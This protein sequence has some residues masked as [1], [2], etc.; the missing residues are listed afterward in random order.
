MIEIDRDTLRDFERAAS[1]EW[2]ETDARGGWAGSTLC[3]A[4]SRRSHRLLWVPE[5]GPAAAAG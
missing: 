5:R 1:L 2:L 3:G 4:H